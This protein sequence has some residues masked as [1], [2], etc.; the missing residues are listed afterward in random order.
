MVARAEGVPAADA[1]GG[2]AQWDA[3]LRA[4]FQETPTV[5]T[6]VFDR[7]QVPFTF[8]PGQ[9]LAVRLPD[10]HD[11]RGDSR[12]FSISSAPS[13]GDRIS[14]T[15]RIGSSPF[16]ERLFQARPGDVAELWGP[17]GDFTPE[18]SRPSVLVG[19]G[20]GITPYRSMIREAA[21]LRSPVPI[22]LVYSSRSAEEILFRDELER[23]SQSWSGL[24]L[25]VTVSRVDGAGTTWR[26]PVGR[27]DAPLIRNA[28][29]GLSNPT[30][31]LCGP[32]RMVTDLQRV[33]TIDVGVRRSDLRTELF[34][35]Y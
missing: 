29:K 24:R 15:T 25:H 12:T 22:S 31:F 17:F 20:I 1:S 16:K 8:R 21:H 28:A 3:V 26:G 35:G 23:L 5:R 6:F 9:Y 14:V 18:P 4:T 27:V 7:P 13:D 34:R 10:V 2:L 30:Y 19:G 11:P 33:L 32:P